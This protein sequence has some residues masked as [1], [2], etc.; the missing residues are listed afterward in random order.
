MLMVVPKESP[1]CPYVLWEEEIQYWDRGWFISSGTTRSYLAS[2]TIFS[3]EKRYV[4][5]Y[6]GSREVKACQGWGDN[7]GW[8]LCGSTHLIQLEGGV[9]HLIGAL[10]EVGAHVVPHH[11]HVA[12]PGFLW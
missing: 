3:L 12:G 4:R 10:L 5:N 9:C 2:I 8:V 11:A 7:P 6:R 1:P